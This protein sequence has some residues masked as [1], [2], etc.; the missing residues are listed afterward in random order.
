M[1]LKVAHALL[2]IMMM[3]LLLAYNALTPI[4]IL[5]KAMEIV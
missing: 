2:I 1:L 4:A 5:V 3:D